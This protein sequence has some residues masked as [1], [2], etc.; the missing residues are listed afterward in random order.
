MEQQSNLLA[1]GFDMCGLCCRESY[2][3]QQ[4]LL[5]DQFSQGL[6]WMMFFG[7][8]DFFWIAYRLRV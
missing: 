4:Q 2:G 6:Q 8:A 1:K 7:K 5:A 3:V